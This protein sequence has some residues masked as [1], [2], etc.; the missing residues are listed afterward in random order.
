MGMLDRCEECGVPLVISNE[1]VWRNHG[2]IVQKRDERDRIIFTESDNLDPLF[3]EIEQIVGLPIEH[4][5]IACI[6]RTY[7]TYCNLFLPKDVSERVNSG[8][9][10]PEALDTK[11]RQLSVAM[12]VGRFEFV[13]M[14]FEGD[15]EDF[16]TV[17]VTEPHSLL[18]CAACHAGAMEALFGRDQGVRYEE[19]SPGVFHVTAFPQE[20]P[21]ELKGRMQLERYSPT[22]GHTELERCGTCGCPKAL[23][24]YKWDFDRGVIVHET[25]KRRM[26][27]MGPNQIDPIFKELEME[28]GET[29]PQVVAEAQRRFTKTGYYS[30]DDYASVE[31]FRDGL[32]MRGLGELKELK[33]KRTGL[34][35]Q[36]ENV[37]LP[38]FLVGMMQGIF[39]LALDCESSVDWQLSE[40]GTL[41][42]EV[43][44]QA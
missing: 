33:I 41:E 23:S 11:L 16:H 24:S 18:M 1:Y 26:A 2:D 17:S 15:D 13:A 12:G 28:L 21:E 35:M 30:M 37:V 7:R 4:I 10:D 43:L 8:E 19:M 36:V 29:I 38:L 14:R 42:L 3:H 22:S 31:E 5:I 20:H 32:A 34:Q 6:R 40:E 39:E 44:P 9:L 25:A 27:V